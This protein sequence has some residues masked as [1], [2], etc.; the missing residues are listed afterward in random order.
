[1]PYNPRKQVFNARIGAVTL[2]T[3]DRSVTLGGENVL[4]FYTFDAPIDHK[5]LIAAEVSDRPLGDAPALR[6]F[7]DGCGT[8]ADMAVRATT[9]PG[10][11]AVC[12]HFESADPNAEDAPVEECVEKAKAVA[13]AVDIPIVVMG[14]GNAEKDAGLFEALSAALEGKNAL[15]CSAREENYR[16]VAPTAALAHGHKVGAESSVDIN[17]AKQLNVLLGQAGIPAGSVCMDVGS[18]A[19]GYGFEYLVSTMDRVKAAALAQNDAQLQMP[20]VTPVSPETWVVKESTAPEEENPGWGDAEERA[21]HME[22]C[23]ATACLVSGS[24]LVIM[25]HPAAIETVA[26]FIDSLA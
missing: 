15:F 2:G 25:R 18:A 23:T 13:A 11:S 9:M 20:I 26:R 21:I 1:M 22:I 6:A 10:V 3:G 12:L 16:R 19:A 14:C 17:L 24:N 8:M 7:Y 4:P 5:P